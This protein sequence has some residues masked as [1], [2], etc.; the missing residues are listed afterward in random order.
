MT[1]AQILT[2]QW[3]FNAACLLTFAVLAVSA[4][5]ADRKRRKGEDE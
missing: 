2:V 5:V 4:F 1:D 3:I